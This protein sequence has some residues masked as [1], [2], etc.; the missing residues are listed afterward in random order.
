MVSFADTAKREACWFSS[1]SSCL[2]FTVWT[3]ACAKVNL[4]VNYVLYVRCTKSPGCFSP[5]CRRVVPAEGQGFGRSPGA[6]SPKALLLHRSKWQ[7]KEGQRQPRCLQCALLL[8]QRKWTR[9]G[10][11][12]RGQKSL[13]KDKRLLVRDAHCCARHSRDTGW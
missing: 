11:C 5:C 8:K 4:R 9:N 3:V 6:Q 12:P 13:R 7:R 1:V 2:L 10:N